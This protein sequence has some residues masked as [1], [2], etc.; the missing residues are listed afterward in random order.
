MA[1]LGAT[2]ILAR[3]QTQQDVQAAD[4]SKLACMTYLVASG[5]QISSVGLDCTL[6]TVDHWIRYNTWHDQ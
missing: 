3:G 2:L 1:A 5:D 6:D 4:N